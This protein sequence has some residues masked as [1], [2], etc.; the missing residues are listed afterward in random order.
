VDFVQARS[1]YGVPSH[2]FCYRQTLRPNRASAFGEA[3]MSQPGTLAAALAYVP[4]WWQE[5]SDPT[6]L[7]ALLGG[8]AK[9][10]GWKACG[11][12]WPTET[13]MLLRTAHPGGLAEAGPAAAELAEA[14]RRI[15]AGEPTVLWVAPGTA[16]R[17]YAPVHLP[18]RPM[19]LVWADRPAGQPWSEADRAYLVL[20]ARAMDR[21]PVVAAATGPVIDPERQAQRLADAPGRV[22]AGQLRRRDRQGRPAGRP[23]HPAVAP[24]QPRRAGEADARVGPRGGRQGGGP[25]A[26]D[27]PGGRAADQGPAADAAGRG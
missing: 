22:A 18:G 20:T 5:T 15:R 16:G 23:V 6:G 14:A 10:C 24:A 26:A 25:A 4:A 19:G 27:A 2:N 12:V 9:A 1:R 17:V 13:P 3:A 21:S 11:F 8:W 7:D